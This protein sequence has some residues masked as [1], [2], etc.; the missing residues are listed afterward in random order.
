M[1]MCLLYPC[2]YALVLP[3]ASKQTQLH[4]IYWGGPHETRQV[5]KWLLYI[6]TVTAA[7]LATPQLEGYLHCC[8]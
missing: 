5:D 3:I 8:T 7:H 4:G 6:V 1:V 2:H